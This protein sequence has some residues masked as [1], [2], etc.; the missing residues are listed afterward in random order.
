MFSVPHLI[1]KTPPI[2]KVKG[3]NN[4]QSVNIVSRSHLVFLI[5]LHLEIPTNRLNI[6][7][8]KS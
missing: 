4:K 3:K 2:S 8:N 1:H 6:L 7:F 5:S